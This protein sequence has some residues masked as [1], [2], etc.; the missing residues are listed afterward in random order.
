MLSHQTQPSASPRRFR[1]SR[2]TSKVHG[3]K[4]RT[5]WLDQLELMRLLLV[6]TPITVHY[7]ALAYLLGINALGASE[8]AAVRIEDVRRNHAR[9]PRRA[10]HR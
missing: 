1:A 3:D 5:H 10:P 8:A 9:L 7:R 2:G 4:S 6:A